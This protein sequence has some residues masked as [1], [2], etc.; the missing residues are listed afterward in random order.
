MN[1]L[2]GIANLIILLSLFSCRQEGIEEMYPQDNDCIQF[3][4]P[5]IEV[6]Q[7]EGT[8][9]VTTETLKK[10]TLANGE[11]FAVWGYCVPNMVGSSTLDYNGATSSWLAKRALS[12]PNVFYTSGTDFLNTVTVGNAQTGSKERKW[13]SSGKGLDGNTNA[14]VGSNADD[15]LYT[16]F[17]YY[18][19]G[20][21]GFTINNGQYVAQNELNV[22]YTMPY[23]N[24]AI[25]DLSGS[26]YVTND[27][28][29]G[30]VE[31]HKRGNGKVQFTFSHLLCALNFQC[32][33]FTEY[34]DYN[35]LQ[36]GEPT[37]KGENLFIKSIRL[38]GTF[39]KTLNMNLFESSS[40]NYSFA[41]TYT[42]IYTI[43][44]SPEGE[45]IY[46]EE[47]DGQETS[48]VLGNPL[49]LLCGTQ[50]DGEDKYLGPSPYVDYDGGNTVL[51]VTN[52]QSTNKGIYLEV[53][54]NYEN[55]GTEITKILPLLTP[56]RSF[57]PHVGVNYTMQLNWLGESFVLLIMPDGKGIWG[58]GEADDDSTDNDDVV[59]E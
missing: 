7:E 38:G 15:Y 44:S 46:F 39:H 54:Y 52:L 21:N 24:G 29:L 20:D 48:A 43:F 3:T 57:T 26:S 45:C 16:F 50:V 41:D 11:S 42:A 27:A 32:N 10:T 49:L 55:S 28:M 8:R 1:K 51:N 12:L 30:M 35:E 14:S 53:V 4:T 34:K 2:C 18:P 31:N 40:S 22:Q 19:V 47:T 37:Q 5:A 58:D 17:A 23:S 6:V 59:F 9:G 25:I 36:N 33:N 13:Y 56:D